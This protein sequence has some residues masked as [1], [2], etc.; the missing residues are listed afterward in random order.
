MSLPY[1]LKK[2]PHTIEYLAD[3][4]FYKIKTDKYSINIQEDKDKEINFISIRNED[5]VIFS[6]MSEDMKK[7]YLDAKNI[8]NNG[9]KE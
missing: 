8:L 3:C 7:I 5:G 2:Y 9:L 4:F 1:F 6:G